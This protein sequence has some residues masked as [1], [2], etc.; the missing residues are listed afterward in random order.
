M[1][2][3]VERRERRV[4]SVMRIFQ[5]K[6]ETSTFRDYQCIRLSV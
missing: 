2:L 4:K 3:A 1:G 5:V 6:A